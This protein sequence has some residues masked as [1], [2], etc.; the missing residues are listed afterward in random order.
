[1]RM[2]VICIYILWTKQR[3]LSLVYSQNCNFTIRTKI[4]PYANVSL[5]CILLIVFK[6]LNM[7]CFVFKKISYYR[8]VVACMDHIQ[9][10]RFKRLAHC[11]EDL[12]IYLIALI[13]WTQILAFFYDLERTFQQSLECVYILCNI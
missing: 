6:C 1:M 2:C 7:K 8:A 4:S 11:L 3:K 10:H 13:F 12:F 5:L 9:S